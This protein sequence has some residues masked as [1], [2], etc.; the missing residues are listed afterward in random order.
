VSLPIGGGGIAAAV[1]LLTMPPLPLALPPSVLVDADFRLPFRVTR[2][3]IS[4]LASVV[5]L[6]SPGSTA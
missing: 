3:A 4:A 6:G 5:S 1:L 2:S